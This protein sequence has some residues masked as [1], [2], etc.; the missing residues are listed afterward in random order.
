MLESTFNELLRQA[1]AEREQLGRKGDVYALREAFKRRAQ[2][3][4]DELGGDQAEL[5]RFLRSL[6]D[7]LD[8]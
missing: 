5:D 3:K 8:I 7:V 2:R 4:L 1:K 6:G